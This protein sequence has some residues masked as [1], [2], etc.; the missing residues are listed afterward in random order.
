MLKFM[1]SNFKVVIFRKNHLY[2]GEAGEGGGEPAGFEVVGVE[3]VVSGQLFGGV[4][5]A[6]VGSVCCRRN[7]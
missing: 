5:A 4:E 7:G 6:I 2:S 1:T 3:A